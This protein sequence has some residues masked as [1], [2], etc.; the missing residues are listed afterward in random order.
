MHPKENDFVFLFDLA[1]KRETAWA[2]EKER[3]PTEKI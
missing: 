2:C 3:Q 1:Q